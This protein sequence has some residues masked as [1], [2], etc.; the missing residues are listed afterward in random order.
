M[1]QGIEA[2]NTI[3][4]QGNPTGG[5]VRGVGIVIDWQDGPLGR[6]DSRKAPN[7]AFVEDVID[8][9][10]QRLVFYQEASAGRFAC[11]ENAIAIHFLI[12][13]LDA[14]DSRTQERERRE[15]EGTHQP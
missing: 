7:G 8:A 10:R 2:T 6:G 11:P 14:L 9:A 3:D 13:A 1:R 4:D 15:V 12:N 5:E